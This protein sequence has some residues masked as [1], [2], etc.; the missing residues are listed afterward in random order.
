VIVAVPDTPE[1][2]AV[3]VAAPLATPRQSPFIAPL[4]T[5]TAAVFDDIQL[6]AAVTLCD[7]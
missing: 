4:S 1:A 2:V 5:V 7:V 6:A 3:I